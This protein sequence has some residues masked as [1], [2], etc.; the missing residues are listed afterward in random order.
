LFYSI[1]LPTI[2]YKHHKMNTTF[3]KE[4]PLKPKRKLFIPDSEEEEEDR[5][6]NIIQ[7][8]KAKKLKIIPFAF[9]KHERDETAVEKPSSSAKVPL[10]E[11]TMPS[12]VNWKTVEVD[13][14]EAEA[15]PYVTND[16]G[17]LLFGK[18]RIWIEK[19]CIQ[20]RYAIKDKRALHSGI[21]IWKSENGRGPKKTI[22]IPLSSEY[23]KDVALINSLVQL[24]NAV[25]QELITNEAISTKLNWK[26]LSEN[27]IKGNPL[28]RNGEDEC[29]FYLKVK[30]DPPYKNGYMPSKI[31]NMVPD[32]VEGENCYIVEPNHKYFNE[33]NIVE[34]DGIDGTFKVDGW[35]AS[36]NGT[37]G[38]TASVVQMRH[39]DCGT[40][41]DLVFKDRKVEK[42]E[43]KDDEEYGFNY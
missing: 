7:P 40:F 28:L 21:G 1:L 13:L 38:L 18:L 33:D 22:S 4:T 17:V 16:G 36:N 5:L 6:M 23:R 30:V 27:E 9:A 2:N 20:P 24:Q 34:Y 32:S 39:Y 15:K 14:N 8:S 11:A 31:W 3:V 43:I 37:W 19:E 10:T 26:H 29:T 35:Y 25:F 42:K 41:T 12:Y